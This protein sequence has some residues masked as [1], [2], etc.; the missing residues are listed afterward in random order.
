MKPSPVIALAL[1]ATLGAPALRAQETN[2]WTFD[3]SVYGLAASMSGNVAVK[4][5]PTDVDIGFDK[6]WDNLK[7]DVLTQGPQLG[8][9]F[10]F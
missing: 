2:K 5:I 9:T 3:V 7:Y 1:A 4:G 6:I 10:S 8:V